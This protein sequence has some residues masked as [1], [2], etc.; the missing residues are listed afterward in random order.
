MDGASLCVSHGYPDF[1]RSFQE[2]QPCVCGQTL[3]SRAEEKNKSFAEGVQEKTR[4]N[5]TSWEGNSPGA[6]TWPLSFLMHPEFD[7]T[8]ERVEV[9]NYCRWFFSRPS[10][11]RGFLKVQGLAQGHSG[12]VACTQLIS[13]K[14]SMDEAQS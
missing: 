4:K 1:S 8:V 7:V 12:R 11:S 5:P 2:T 13:G 14:I 9:L 6:D 10:G 3:P